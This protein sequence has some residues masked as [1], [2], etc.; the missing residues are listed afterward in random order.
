MAL[1]YA[2]VF[3]RYV[4]NYIR[5]VWCELMDKIRLINRVQELL[6]IEAEHKKLQLRFSSISKRYI[7]KQRENNQLRVSVYHYIRTTKELRD[8][9]MVLEFK[10]ADK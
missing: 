8:K 10:L 7:K 5:G 4:I 3:E 2:E 9:L 1:Q 6:E